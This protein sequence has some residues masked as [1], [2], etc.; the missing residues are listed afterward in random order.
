MD[1]EAE[2]AN[3]AACRVVVR[4]IA[5]NFGIYRE[6]GRKL[7]EMMFSVDCDDGVG[8]GVGVGVFVCL[9]EGCLM[10]GSGWYR[11]VVGL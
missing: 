3:L 9:E 5:E 8:V 6:E 10:V 1:G 7:G 2:T 4:N 11:M